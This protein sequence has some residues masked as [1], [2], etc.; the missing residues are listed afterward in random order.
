M[1]T[2]EAENQQSDTAKSPTKKF[3]SRSSFA[4][5]YVSEGLDKDLVTQLPEMEYSEHF[6]GL[7]R[8]DAVEVLE[9]TNNIELLLQ[10][11]LKDVPVIISHCD[12]DLCYTYVK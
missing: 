9:R 2:A 11:V 6:R 5:M 10:M 3:S 4:R 12:K 8:L 1:E 7:D